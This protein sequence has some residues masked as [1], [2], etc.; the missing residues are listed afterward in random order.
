M[1]DLL[2]HVV[3]NAADHWYELGLLLL[4]AKYESH[5]H[6]IVSDTRNDARTCCKK[7]FK[8]WLD[9][10]VLASWDKVIEA[11]IL[12]GLNNEASDIKQLLEQG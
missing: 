4:G 8:R 5:L 3:P 12:V 11:L 9:T 6:Y 10:D 7:M 2:I 1:R